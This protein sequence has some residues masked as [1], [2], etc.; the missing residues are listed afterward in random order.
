MIKNLLLLFLLMSIFCVKTVQANNSINS[1]KKNI[2]IDSVNNENALLYNTLPKDKD[3]NYN[4]DVDVNINIQESE[5][6]LS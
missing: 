4:Q 6:K 2:N 5:T 3:N 1:D